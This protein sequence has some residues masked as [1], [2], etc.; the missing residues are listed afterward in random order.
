MPRKK[1]A[2][3][4]ITLGERL[5]AARESAGLSQRALAIAAGISSGNLTDIEAGRYK[6]NFTAGLTLAAVLRIDPYELAGIARLPDGAVLPP[7][8]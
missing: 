7:E 2:P 3:K 8:A 1:P 4:P 5:R 6:P